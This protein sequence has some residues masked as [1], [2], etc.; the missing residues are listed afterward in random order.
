M[1]FLTKEVVRDVMSPHW[2]RIQEL[3]LH[4]DWGR[5]EMYFFGRRRGLLRGQRKSRQSRWRFRRGISVDI[6]HSLPFCMIRKYENSCAKCVTR[7]SVLD[8]ASG[9]STGLHADRWE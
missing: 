8:T 7:E 6:S 2:T 5:E 1:N 4:T 9:P 3:W